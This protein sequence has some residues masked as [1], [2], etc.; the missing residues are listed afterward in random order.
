MSYW[1][2]ISLGINFFTFCRNGSS[3]C[4]SGYTVMCPHRVFMLPDYSGRFLP[5]DA[6][7]LPSVLAQYLPG[8]L[9]ASTSWKW[10][11]SVLTY[12]RNLGFKS[13]PSSLL[14][15]SMPSIILNLQNLAF[16]TED[17]LFHWCECISPAESKLICPSPTKNHDRSGGRSSNVF[18]V[19]CYCFFKSLK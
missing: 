4:C 2:L 8:G 13:I 12:S 1:W 7:P 16:R 3:E 9:T 15:K 14:G 11:G 19:M 18:L 5:E 10:R 6:E 17:K